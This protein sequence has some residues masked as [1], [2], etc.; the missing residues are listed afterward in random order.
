MSVDRE[1]RMNLALWLLAGGGM[2]MTVIVAYL[3]WQ[4]AERGAVWPMLYVCLSALGIIAIVMTTY[5]FIL[6]RTG[7]K[8]SAGKD[9]I[10][11]QD[12]GPA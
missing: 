2:A 3:A 12:G 11:I 8:L 6:G 9:G 4:L 10:E 7:I 1:K 5:G